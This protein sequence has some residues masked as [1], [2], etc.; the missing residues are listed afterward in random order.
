ME[1]YRRCILGLLFL[2]VLSLGSSGLTAAATVQSQGG[3]IRI[4]LNSD[5]TGVFTVP[6]TFVSK[7]ARAYLDAMGGKVAGREISLIEMD[8]TSEPKVALEVA[9][10]C[11]EMEKV[12]ILA[13]VVHSG[14]ALAVKGYADKVRIP[15]VGFSMAGVEQLTLDDPSPYS[16]TLSR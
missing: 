7:G 12:H 1:K 10:K 5:L 2:T 6:G 4:G 14:S 9:K 16:N 8:N 3:P 11:V 15:Y 13:G